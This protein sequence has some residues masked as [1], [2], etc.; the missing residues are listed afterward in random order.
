MVDASA[1]VRK[2]VS[3]LQDDHIAADEVEINP[4][5]VIPGLEDL[6]L[7]ESRALDMVM[8]YI[9]I[10]GY[11]LKTHLAQESSMVRILNSFLT[12]MCRI[13]SDYGG[14][15][16]DVSGDRVMAAF[17]NPTRLKKPHQDA[18]ECAL[19]MQTVIVNAIN[20]LLSRLKYGQLSC[21]IGMDAGRVLVARF[22]YRNVNHLVFIGDPANIGAKLEDRAEGGEIL[23]TEQ[24]YINRPD[25]MSPVNSWQLSERNV[26]PGVKSFSTKCWFAMQ[27]PTPPARVPSLLMDY[28]TGQQPGQRMGLLEALTT[29]PPPPPLSPEH[30]ALIYAM[31]K[32]ENQ[33]KQGLL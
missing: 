18:V 24:V 4:G 30:S 10:R 15:V 14:T 12:E 20:P 5:L 32:F 1:Y 26:L 9:D 6:R 23:M 11:S 33:R 19:M 16:A 28:L 3:R 29:P 22:G 13:V 7:G 27:A 17:G 8:L 25:Y 31:L 2:S 21:G